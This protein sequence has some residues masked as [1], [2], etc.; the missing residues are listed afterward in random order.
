MVTMSSRHVA[1]YLLKQAFVTCS[2]NM[3]ECL[4]KSVCNDII[5]CRMDKASH[6]TSIHYDEVM[7]DL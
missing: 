2:A 1:L 7:D 4:V 3:R 5:R 6:G